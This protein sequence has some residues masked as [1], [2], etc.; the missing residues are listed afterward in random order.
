MQDIKNKVLGKLGVRHQRRYCAQ[1]QYV[2]KVSAS[3]IEGRIVLT[4][5]LSD[6]RQAVADY[7]ENKVTVLMSILHPVNGQVPTGGKSNGKF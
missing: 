5:T 1:V 6:L 3:I 7:L 4:I 2:Q